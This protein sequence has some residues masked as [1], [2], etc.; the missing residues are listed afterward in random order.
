MFKRMNRHLKHIVQNKAC[1]MASIV[2]A[3]A[4]EEF[5]AQ[6]VGYHSSRFSKL[7]EILS[8]MPTNYNLVKKC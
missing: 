3:Y 1:S 5:I 4:K 8:C 7:I 2:K 6:T